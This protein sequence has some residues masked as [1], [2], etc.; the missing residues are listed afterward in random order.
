MATTT[1][2]PT[3]RHPVAFAVTAALLWL[4]MAGAVQGKEP[5]MKGVGTDKGGAKILGRYVAIDNVCAWPNLT[6]LRDGTIAAI[7]YNHPS[8]LQGPGDLQCWAS[9]DGVGLWEKRGIVAPHGPKTTRGNVAAG[10]AHNGDLVALASGWGYA[11]N[12]RTCRLAPWVCRSTDGGRT[13]KVDE[14]EASLVYPEGLSRDNPKDIPVPFGDIVALADKGLAAPVYDCSGRVWVLFSRDDGRTWTESAL[15]M[16]QHGTE[17][18]LLRLRA[19]RWLAATRA[20][21]GRD[22]NLPSWGMSLSVS[23]D[24]GR[25]WSD[26]VKLTAPGRYPGSFL[27]LQGGRILLTFGMRDI[28]AVGYRLSADEGR[29]WSDTTVL[30]SL[31]SWKGLVFDPPYRERDLGYP[32][33]VQLSNGT[34]ITAY[35][36]IGIEQHTR[37]HMGVVRWRVKAKDE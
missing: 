28:M 3:R 36:T 26:P 12:Y 34:L 22:G 35:Y 20:G 7:V 24:E 23:A 17:C 11:P 29:T 19:D 37:Y 30:V 14:A 13:W 25:T 32:S 18:A 4:G 5:K 15:L 6:M 8:H 2:N 1:P 16:D 21:K 33:T 31:P 27:R 10:L 9:S